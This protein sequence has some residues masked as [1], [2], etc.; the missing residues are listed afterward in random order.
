M[1][2][3]HHAFHAIFLHVNWHCHADKPLL[4]PKVELACR[5][6]LEAYCEKHGGVR[7]L[8]VGGTETHVHL[9][10][11]VEP[12]ICPS[13]FIGKLK[14]AASH[15]LNKRFGRA[16]VKWQVGYG[17]VSF[18]ERDLRGVLRYIKNQKEHHA[19]GTVNRVLE[20]CGVLP[21]PRKT[22]EASERKG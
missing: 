8:A 14:G 16:T 4:R 5:S 3:K 22:E 18:A 17:V 20:T 15:D 7:L 1:S 13:E 21:E 11:Q 12:T 19:K 6:Y 9:A 2:P 10:L